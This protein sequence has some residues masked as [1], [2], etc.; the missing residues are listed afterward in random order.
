[1]AFE[2]EADRDAVVAVLSQCQK[3]LE[4]EADLHGV[5]SLAERRNLLAKEPNIQVEH[6]AVVGGGVLTEHEFW[7]GRADHAGHRMQ[8]RLST[9]QH[10][11]PARG[12]GAKVGLSNA[13]VEAVERM[14]EGMARVGISK[15]IYEF[16][17]K[18]LQRREI[19][20][21]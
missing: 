7:R 8:R 19:P 3:E 9:S 6:A 14:D 18:G 11:S 16:T 2:T 4:L 17:G 13:L 20:C 15:I 21:P 1:M 10:R 12:L 5:P